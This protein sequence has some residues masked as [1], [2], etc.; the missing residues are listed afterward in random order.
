M[1]FDI[2]P[3]EVACLVSALGVEGSRLTD[4]A[5]AQPRDWRGD[6]SR[7]RLLVRAGVA[8]DLREKLRAHLAR[9][10]KV[11]KAFGSTKAAKR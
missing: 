8:H 11:G 10:R 6:E 5:R 7:R 3:A 4:L 9:G 1:T 2:N